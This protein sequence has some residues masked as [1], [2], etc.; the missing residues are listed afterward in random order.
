MTSNLK[1][2]FL[3]FCFIV[4][5][6]GAVFTTTMRA[7]AEPAT[8]PAVEVNGPV[9]DLAYCLSVALS[10]NFDIQKAKERIEKERGV[11][12]EARGRF[13]PSLDAT[14]D[15]SKVDEGRIPTF[16]NQQFGSD[17]VWNIDIQASQNV[18]SGGR[19]L[20]LYKRARLLEEAASFELQTVINEVLLSVREQFYKVLLAR[21]ELYVQEENVKLLEEEF[22]SEKNKL[23]AG[24]VSDFNVLRAEVE[25]ANARSPYIRARNGLKLAFEELN[26]VLGVR[27]NN[28]THD[29]SVIKAPA[30]E[31]MVKFSLNPIKLTLE[32][33]LDVSTRERPEIKRLELTREA[34]SS[35]VR[36]E[37]ADYLPKLSVFA[38]YGWDKDQF[39]KDFGDELHG[40]EAGVRSDWNVFNGLQTTA[41]VNQA[42]SEESQVRLSLAQT[43][44]D[45]DVEV[46]RTFSSLEE[47]QELVQAS[48]K[49]VEQGVEGLRLAKARF[50]AGA[51][52]QLEVLDTQVALTEARSNQVRALHDYFLA[53][54]SLEKAMGTIAKY[55]T[56]LDD[57]SANP[58]QA[59]QS[60]AAK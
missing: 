14:G 46:R 42:R 52:T 7:N 27:P 10:H 51:G 4:A 44:N 34:Q 3:G 1:K 2:I 18:F 31:E 12:I 6:T 11:K 13:F 22:K 49:V 21:A 5:Q 39:T 32:Q 38:G 24:T 53:E 57:L 8:N 30:F 60:S 29:Q 28:S 16:G 26:R 33:A 9:Y 50:D 40:W 17:Q 48:N 56:Q 25:L 20:F 54:A 37:Q 23:D 59:A 36:A 58:T 15:L 47:A 41:R 45:V 19:D 35:A 55:Q 43:R